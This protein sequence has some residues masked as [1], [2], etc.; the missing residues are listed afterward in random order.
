MY[1]HVNLSSMVCQIANRIRLPDVYDEESSI[2]YTANAR[3]SITQAILFLVKICHIKYAQLWTKPFGEFLLQCVNFFSH[4]LCLLTF[5]VNCL[6]DKKL[7]MSETDK[8]LI[9][10]QGKG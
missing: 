4:L 1:Q 10:F 5:L 9:D 2:T 3:F 6:I 8:C 7:T